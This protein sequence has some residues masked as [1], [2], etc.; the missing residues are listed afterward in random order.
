MTIRMR[1]TQRPVAGARQAQLRA[2]VELRP[3]ARTLGNALCAPIISLVP[4][5][6]I[7]PKTGHMVTAGT[8][9]VREET[10]E[11]VLTDV[12]SSLKAH[13]FQNII[14][15]GDSGGNQAGQKAVAGT[16]NAQQG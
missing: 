11:A 6:G 8:L 16:L 14:L 9:T 4:K 15:I 13:G 2:E 10:F 7:E 12:V 3:F 5:G 1:A